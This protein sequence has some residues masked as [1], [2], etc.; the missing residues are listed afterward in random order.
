MAREII[1]TRPLDERETS[2]LQAVVYE[3]IS[4]GRPVGSRSFVQKYS[5]SISPATMRNVMFD[6]ESMEFVKQPHTSAGR[7]PTDKG[8]RFYV[9]SLLD[10]YHFS[11]KDRVI[12]VK[13]E[14]VR[15]EVQL[16]KIFSLITRM[17]SSESR[18]AAIMLTPRFDF[19]VVKRIVLVPMDNNEVLF[20]LVTRT[21]MVLTRKVMISSTVPQDELYDYSKYLTGELSGY[22]INEIRDTVFNRLRK[23]K[24][25]GMNKEMALDI[26]QLAIAD[27]EEPNL[28]V[29]GI[30]NLLKIPEMVEEGRL[31]S[32]LSIIEEKNI[33][34]R[35]LERALEN[36]G[37]WTL[38]GEEIDEERVTGCSMVSTS[39]KIGNKLVG[40]IGVIGPTRM[41]YEKVVP[42]V[43]YTGRVVTELLTEVSK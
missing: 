18:Y 30:E 1:N 40:A 28:H 24:A 27:Y 20:I 34:R 11:L 25:E 14:A 9:N 23:E 29:D 16:D 41:D 3:H 32:L 7:I 2:I 19:T 33:L 35:I 38:I 10:S 37:V 21:G 12:S 42:L 15:R 22:S 5:F 39:Y 6:L 26:A 43:D 4:T 31:Q 17:L 13:E 8:Y 36:E